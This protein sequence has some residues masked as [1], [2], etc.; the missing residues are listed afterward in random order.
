M[1]FWLLLVVLALSGCLRPSAPVWTVVPDA[2]ELISRLQT[3]AENYQS[4]DVAAQVNLTS[5]GNFYSTQQ[6]IL[7]EKPNL[8]RSDVLTGFGQLVMQL[9]TDGDEF[10][11]FLYTSIPGKFY[12]GQASRDNLSRFIRIPLRVEDLVAL[13]L[14]SPPL[15]SF[16]LADVVVSGSDLLLS[17]RGDGQVQKVRFNSQL[18]LVEVSYLCD[19]QLLLR[20]SYKDFDASGFPLEMIIEAPVDET[21]VRL[22]LAELV[23]NPSLDAAR[24]RLK[25]PANVI[26]ESL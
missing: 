16:D 22:S 25:K 19:Q 15:I 4:L 13:V 10:S 3:S 11:V 18:Q 1:R 9:A 6:F 12:R 20:T 2:K 7:V 8:L 26:E 17:L 21:R 5:G 24:F 14:Y 23:L